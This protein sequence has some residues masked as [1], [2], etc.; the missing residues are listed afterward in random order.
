MKIN[1]RKDNPVLLKIRKRVESF[2]KENINSSENLIGIRKKLTRNFL[3]GGI[4]VPKS[5]MNNSQYQVRRFGTMKIVAD[6]NSE[7]IIAIYINKSD[8]FCFINK[9]Q[10]KDLDKLYNIK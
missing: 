8:K 9:R 1:K 5:R 7:T 3:L 4:D 2:Y 6:L 10:L